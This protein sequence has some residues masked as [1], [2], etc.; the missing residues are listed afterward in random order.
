MLFFIRRDKFGGVGGDKGPVPH[1][2][3]QEIFIR[4][5]YII[6]RWELYHTII[7]KKHHMV[8]NFDFLL[9]FYHIKENYMSAGCWFFTLKIIKL[10]LGAGDLPKSGYLPNM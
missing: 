2:L 1:S 6:P 10:A 4:G 8:A 5:C 7:T 3:P 9:G